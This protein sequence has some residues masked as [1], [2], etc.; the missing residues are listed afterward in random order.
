MKLKLVKTIRFQ[1]RDPNNQQMQLNFLNN[2]L[3]TSMRRLN[4]IE[5]GSSRRFFDA[6]SK[7]LIND[8]DLVVYEGYIANFCKLETGLFLKV[9]A[10]SKIVRR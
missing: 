9:D 10:V 8:L 5:I 2:L 7:K 4:F 6:S 1:D 3:R